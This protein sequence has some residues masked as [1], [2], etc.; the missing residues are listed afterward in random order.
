MEITPNGMLLYHFKYGCSLSLPKISEIFLE[1]GILDLAMLRLYR[2]YIKK[3]THK[4]RVKK[5]EEIQ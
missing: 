5:L 3:N 4:D 1:K 2:V